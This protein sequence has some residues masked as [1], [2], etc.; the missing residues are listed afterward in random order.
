MRQR[1]IA[2][3]LGLA[4]ALTGAPAVS[5]APSTDTNKNALTI[6]MSCGSDSL[7]GATILHNAAVA[8]QVVAGDGKAA[9]IVELWSYSDAARTQDEALWFTTAG[10]S[11]NGAEI[12][13]CTWWNALYPD[14]YWSG[15]VTIKPTAR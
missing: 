7:V 15:L 6:T 14:L 11:H 3:G 2:T 13:S 8:V 4:L 1:W 5:A 10:F 12:V 9:Q